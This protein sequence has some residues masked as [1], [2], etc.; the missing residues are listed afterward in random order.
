MI[1]GADGLVASIPIGNGSVAM[2]MFPLSDDAFVR[3]R[4]FSSFINGAVLKHP[5]RTWVALQMEGEYKWTGKWFGREGDPEMSTTV[6]LL[7]RDGRRMSMM[8][9]TRPSETEISKQEVNSDGVGNRARSVGSWNDESVLSS[10]AIDSLTAAS[11]ITVPKVGFI[12]KLLAGYLL[13]LVPLN[14]LVFRLIGR[15][16]YAWV[17]VPVIAIIGATV[18]A[19]SVQLD[20]GF[21]RSETRLSC[22]ELY[23][24]YDR[25]HQTTYVSLYTSLQKLTKYCSPRRWRRLTNGNREHFGGASKA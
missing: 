13:V 15:V 14:W 16:E 8:Q 21:S 18:V 2:T 9:K 7:T 22:L 5:P 24:G 17:A 10:S 1:E 25:A 20:I 11:G 3:W 6:R 12:I 23:E 19:K 4:G